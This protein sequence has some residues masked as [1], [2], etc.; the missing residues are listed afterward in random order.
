M[1]VHE[2]F[3]VRVAPAAAPVRIPD[4]YAYTCFVGDHYVTGGD[5]LQEVL[6]E[7]LTRLF[8]PGARGEHVVFVGPGRKRVAAVVRDR[9]PGKPAAVYGFE[10][11]FWP[12]DGQTEA[13]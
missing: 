1:T 8:E 3:N 2:S 11:P 6:H 12:G 5:T 9:G 7:V 13:E 4:E 10:Y